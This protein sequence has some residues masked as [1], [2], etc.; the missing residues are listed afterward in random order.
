[1]GGLAGDTLEVKFWILLPVEGVGLIRL[2]SW[3]GWGE[4][5]EATRCTRSFGT[6]VERTALVGA[7]AGW[8]AGSVR[9]GTLPSPWLFFLFFCSL[10]PELPVSGTV[11]DCPSQSCCYLFYCEWV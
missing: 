3:N 1:M 4:L 5:V 10:S 7:G 6:A 8:G 9:W 11:S 2:S